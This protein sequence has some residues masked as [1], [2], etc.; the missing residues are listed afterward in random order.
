MENYT[1]VRILFVD[2]DTI[3]SFYKDGYLDLELFD[4]RLRLDKHQNMFVVLKDEVPKEQGG[5]AS[6]LTRIKGKRLVPLIVSDKTKVSSISPRNKE[7]AFSL[8]LLMDD[9]VEVVALTG[10]AGTGKTLLSLAVALHKL[11]EKKYNRVILTRTMSQVGRASIGFLPGGA[12]EK[13]MP[14]NQGCL[15]NFENL[16]GAKPKDMD[17]VLEQLRIEFIP[18]QLVR[19][20]S[21]PKALVIVDEAQNTT[22]HEMLTIGTRIGEGSKFIILG[23]LNQRDEKMTRDATGLYKFVNAA[24]AKENTTV[25]S[26][27]LVKCERGNVPRIFADIFENK[28]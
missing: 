1:G 25:G 6:A 2:K 21:W 3:G 19:G 7:Q 9:S 28:E 14:F 15:C 23:D 10:S 12:G 27:E 13:F 20:A 11:Q 26:I 16:L 24:Q 5:V 18:I 4:G 17:T 8:E 22:P